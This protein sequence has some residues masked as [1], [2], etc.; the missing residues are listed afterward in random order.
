MYIQMVWGLVEAK[1]ICRPF[2]A[3]GIQNI[4]YPFDSL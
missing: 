4:K 3:S 2:S 1:E